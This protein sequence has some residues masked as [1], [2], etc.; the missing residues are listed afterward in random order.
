MLASPASLRCLPW[1][2]YR[3]LASWE[4]TCRSCLQSLSAA[5]LKTQVK[6]ADKGPGH[7]GSQV[8][9]QR[10]PPSSQEGEG[11]A[12]TSLC[13]RG[14]TWCV[15]HL[16]RPLCNQDQE[17]V[18]V[19]HEALEAGVGQVL[20]LISLSRCLVCIDINYPI[21]HLDMVSQV[22]GEIPSVKGILSTLHW[23][24]E[25]CTKRRIL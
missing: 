13:P 3:A 11:A 4:P 24:G 5:L 22:L 18:H 10:V 20:R 2:C 6:R 23:R 12:L 16:H 17:E 8:C 19:I 25:H 15:V 9:H 1:L 14:R 7:L 21:L